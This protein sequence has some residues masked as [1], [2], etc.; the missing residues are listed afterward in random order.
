MS[1]WDTRAT[2]TQQFC[3]QFCQIEI[4]DRRRNRDFAFIFL[5]NNSRSTP[6]SPFV[7]KKKSME[8][9]G[10]RRTY[11]FAL[12]GLNVPS[13]HVAACGLR[14]TVQ[15]SRARALSLTLDRFLTK[16]NNLQSVKI[17]TAKAMRNSPSSCGN[18][19]FFDSFFMKLQ[20][21]IAKTMTDYVSIGFRMLIRYSIYLSIYAGK[22]RNE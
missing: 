12:A 17:Q 15:R 13:S 18:S 3:V 11:H 16:L 21:E 20:V 9:R 2:P 19:Y 1:N 8:A 10:Q 4:R 14:K 22:T 7:H 6:K 5:N